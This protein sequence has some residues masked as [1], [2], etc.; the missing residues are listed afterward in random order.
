M[1]KYIPLI[2]CLVVVIG[3]VLG[4]RAYTV[5]RIIVQRDF[6][7]NILYRISDED[8]C[9]DGEPSVIM[10]GD[11]AYVIVRIERKDGTVGDY[12]GW[13]DATPAEL[14]DSWFSLPDGEKVENAT[15]GEA[16]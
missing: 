6:T 12:W 3:L 13:E 16:G 7:H 4:V 5:G 9:A 8:Q 2:L 15:N 14:D 11:E 10:L 1:K